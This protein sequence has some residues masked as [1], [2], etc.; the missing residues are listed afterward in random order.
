M[1][2]YLPRFET[3]NVVIWR[4]TCQSCVARSTSVH[5]SCKVD[6][7]ATEKRKVSYAVIAHR[8]EGR[9]HDGEMFAGSVDTE[10]FEKSAVAGLA[11]SR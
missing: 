10:T 7:A 6:H 2:P 4:A 3:S 1:K 8:Y 9:T 11:W 5:D